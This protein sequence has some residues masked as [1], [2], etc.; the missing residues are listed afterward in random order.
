MYPLKRA[1]IA[2]LKA[3]KAFTKGPSKYANF[4]DIFSQKLAVK[5]PKYTGI[6]N[7]AIKL[8]NN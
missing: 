1:Y 2:Y 7:Y 4:E 3:D 6:N 5:L 8:V